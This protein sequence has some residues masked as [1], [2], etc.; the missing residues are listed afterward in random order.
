MLRTYDTKVICLTVELLFCSKVLH[1]FVKKMETSVKFF[2]NVLQICNFFT[3]SYDVTHN[4]EV[5]NRL[6]IRTKNLFM[7]HK[8]R[9]I[10]N[11]II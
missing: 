4:E 10:E 3:F 7:L 2:C 5:N 8:Q 9:I 1:I 6:E 11:Y